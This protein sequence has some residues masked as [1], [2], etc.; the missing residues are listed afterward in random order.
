MSL[1]AKKYLKTFEWRDYLLV[2]I[3]LMLYA[4]GL[5]GF[6]VPNKIVTGGLAGVSV[7]INYSTGIPVWVSIL[8]INCCLLVIAWFILGRKFVIKTLFGA[9][10]LTLMIGIAEKYLTHSLL[11]SADPLMASI[12]GAICC[13]AGLGLVYSVN[14]T[15]GGT[16]IVGAIITKYRYVS[17]GRGLMYVDVVIILSSWFL[18][19]SLETIIYGLI[20]IAVLYYV[21]DLV[22]SGSR[23][24]VQ[25]LIF[26]TKYDEIASHINSELHRG[27]TVIDGTG[28]YS[29]K[30]QKVLVVLAR[31]TESTPIFRLVKQ[32]DKDAFI[33]QSNV[34][35]VY[36]KGFDQMK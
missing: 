4:I 18:F 36:G 19:Q 8:V 35:G 21:V 1:P 31:K 3:G 32:I 5:T 24:S 30:P 6:L 10:G 17:M 15:T 9:F 16:D 11:P 26:S 7:L 2:V 28:W 25:F 23:Q 12:I 34:V 22:I 14:S 29:K 33:S 20:I 13:G 27:C